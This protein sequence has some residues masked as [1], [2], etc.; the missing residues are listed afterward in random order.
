M[1]PIAS[2]LYNIFI[3]TSHLLFVI[4]EIC[5]QGRRNSFLNFGFTHKSFQQGRNN[6]FFAFSSL[7]YF[8]KAHLQGRRNSCLMFSNV[9]FIEQ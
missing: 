4:N 1:N 6:S 2:K 5:L 8:I 7:L 3:I 9:F